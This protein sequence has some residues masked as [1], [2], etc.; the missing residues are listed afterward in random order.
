MTSLDPG[1]W[2]GHDGDQPSPGSGTLS[3]PPHPGFFYEQKP[4]RGMTRSPDI[5]E[6]E[7]RPLVTPVAFQSDMLGALR[8]MVS[9]VGNAHRVHL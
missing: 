1:G 8:R 7:S 6:P 4:T 2:T 9:R 5:F 3:L